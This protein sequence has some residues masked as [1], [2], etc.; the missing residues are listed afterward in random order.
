MSILWDQRYKACAAFWLAPIPRQSPKGDKSKVKDISGKTKSLCELRKWHETDRMDWPL[1]L[2]ADILATHSQMQAPR[3]YSSLMLLVKGLPTQGTRCESLISLANL[4]SIS[5]ISS[6]T[7]ISLFLFSS[8]LFFCYFSNF[9]FPSWLAQ[10][11][12]LKWKLFSKFILKY[13]CYYNILFD[14]LVI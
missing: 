12:C 11:I 8:G 3:R 9:I 10:Y 14:L 4:F 7:F 1:P 13:F 5:L 6:L 2:E